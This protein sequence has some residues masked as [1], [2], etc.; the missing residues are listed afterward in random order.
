MRR[1]LVKIRS[2][3]LLTSIST[4]AVLFIVIGTVFSIRLNRIVDTN[5]AKELEIMVK[6]TA[7]ATELTIQSTINSYLRGIAEENK[8]IIG[9]FYQQYLD[10][11]ITKEVMDSTINDIILSQKI[12][13]TGYPLILSGTGVVLNH[14][15]QRLIGVNLKN[16]FEFV[17]DM[18]SIDEG[19]MEYMWKNPG[20]EIERAK[21]LYQVRFEPLDYIISASSY[22]EEFMELIDIE[23]LSESILEHKIRE[24][25]YLFIIDGEGK[26]I[27]HPSLKYGE[28]SLKVVNSSGRRIVKE[29]IEAKEGSMLYLW[30]NSDGLGEREKIAYF[31]TMSNGWLV[32][33]SAYTSE[34][35]EPWLIIS[36]SLVLFMVVTI[37]IFSIILFF[38]MNPI[39]QP[40][41]EVAEVTEEISKGVLT[42]TI[43]EQII[44]R[45]D[46]I[47]T[48][49]KS[50]DKMKKNLTEI[51][52]TILNSIKQ[53]EHN[54]SIIANDNISLSRR[55]EQ[56]ATALEETYTAID[57]MNQ[58]LKSNAD[59]TKN[60][61]ILSRE[62]ATQTGAGSSSV[63]S[64][65]ESMNEINDSSNRISDIIEVI[66]NIAF[67]TNLLALNASIEA[68][69]AGEQG[70][71]FAV[72]AV[73]V[74]KLAKRSDKAAREISEIIKSSNN[75]VNEGVEIANRAGEVLVEINKSVKEVTNLVGEI[76][77]TSQEQLTS[78]DEID[79]TLASLDKNT[80]MNSTMV[81]KATEATERLS[82]QAKELT[83][84]MA[85]F[86]LEQDSEDHLLLE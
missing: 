23:I 28:D 54:S 30:E 75:R 86:T 24:T 8:S 46:E 15:A 59:N 18:L 31:I 73:E 76:S 77:A 79:K 70:K 81:E 61:D 25:G 19:Y 2:K 39:I 83:Q 41:F 43:D 22:K 47:G 10:G 27:V 68:A 71:G 44:N 3:I 17:R 69:R 60:A 56:Q 48:L 74:R 37:I 42:V 9:E 21:S 62:S 11:T 78:V 52:S 29:M 32:G 33:S 50:L 82:K 67:Q 57:K 36:I 55:T 45:R 14:P 16:D 12:G 26:S 40:L 65:I 20:E 51:V 58:S 80:Q 4:L 5:T 13:K 85:F 53:I 84:K 64:V 63:N 49:V 66:N 1:S 6:Q 72:V 7:D 34:I 35:K 38:T